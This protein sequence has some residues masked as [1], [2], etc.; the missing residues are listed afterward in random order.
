[1]ITTMENEKKDYQAIK[2]P[3]T[4]VI[5]FVFI[6]IAALATWLLPGGVYEK[7]KHA[8]TGR[9]IVIPTS[10]KYIDAKH[11]GIWMS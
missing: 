6:L 1:M 8:A 11:M 7:V 9:M 5:I 3:H 10:F 4:Y 2:I